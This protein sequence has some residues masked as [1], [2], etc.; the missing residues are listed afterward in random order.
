MRPPVLRLRPCRLY[1]GKVINPV[2]SMAGE[3]SLATQLVGL[4]CLSKVEEVIL[5]LDEKIPRTAE[6]VKV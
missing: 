1:S 5:V 6:L 2:A 4:L 3:Q